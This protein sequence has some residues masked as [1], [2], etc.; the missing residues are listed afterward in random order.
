MKDSENHIGLSDVE[1]DVRLLDKV[2]VSREYKSPFTRSSFCSYLL[3]VPELTQYHHKRTA[4][5]YQK[6]I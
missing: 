6:K 2:S 5:T 1:F 4:N 3:G